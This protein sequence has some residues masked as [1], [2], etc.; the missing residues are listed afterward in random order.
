[1]SVLTPTFAHSCR[2]FTATAWNE[3]GVHDSKLCL[4][5]IYSTVQYVVHMYIECS[6]I[7]ITLC[8]YMHLWPTQAKQQNRL[9][10]LNI[11]QKWPK[12]A[13]LNPIQ[14]M[15]HTYLTGRCLPVVIA[16]DD[17]LYTPLVF[18][19]SSQAC[20]ALFRSQSYL[21]KQSIPSL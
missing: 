9:I 20:R 15:K 10:I 17:C 21:V 11:Y 1:M 7:I 6:T 8:W 12:I 13:I 16:F 3:R 4:K 19:N 18:R 14:Y 5:T 2:S